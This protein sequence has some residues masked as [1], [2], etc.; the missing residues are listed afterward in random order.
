MIAVC[1]DFKVY[2]HITLYFIK[3]SK[4]DPIVSK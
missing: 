3:M 4:G 1:S 2:K